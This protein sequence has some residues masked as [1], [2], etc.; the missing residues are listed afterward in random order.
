MS[1]HPP[2]STSDLPTPISRRTHLQQLFSIGLLG[3]ALPSSPTPGRKQIHTVLGP[4]DPADLGPTLVHEHVLVDFIGAASYDPK[5]W[6][7]DRVLD[8]L[9]PALRETC[10]AGVRTIMECTPAWIG[11]D[12]ALCARLAKDSGLHLLTNTGLYGARNNLFIPQDAL[13]ASPEQLA[14]HWIR[15]AREGIDGTGIRPGF[16]KIGVDRQTPLHPFHATLSRAAAL[17]HKET[18][19]TITSHTG[20]ADAAK[21][22]LEILESEGVNA[23]AFVFAHAQN[24]PG[25]DP[26]LALARRGC[27]ISLDGVHRDK[28]AAYV[29]HLLAFRD[30]GLLHRVLLSHDAGWFRPREIDHGRSRFRGYTDLFTHLAPA[31]ETAGFPK[32]KLM[33]LIVD[34]PRTLLSGPCSPV[35]NAKRIVES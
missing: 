17:T 22:Q 16:I 30:A 9:L 2:P 10:Q 1:G 20:S 26:L 14:A 4:V 32:D 8:F 27:W 24:E 5:A 21:A 6:S 3:A 31:L 25:P 19:L 28:T 13:R 29:A 33:S 34:N 23:D 18:G 12:P 35:Q 15:E 7:H 11:R